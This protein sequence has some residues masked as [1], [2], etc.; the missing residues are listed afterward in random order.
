MSRSL[1]YTV[2]L[3]LP[4]HPRRCT[5]SSRKLAGLLADRVLGRAARL[6]QVQL[7]QGGLWVLAQTGPRETP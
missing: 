1:A 7:E 2:R 4:G 3:W 6:I 5:G